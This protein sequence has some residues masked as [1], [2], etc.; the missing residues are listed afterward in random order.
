[1]S[2]T[3]T[4]KIND[5]R[6]IQLTDQPNMVC[7]IDYEYV[8]VNDNDR[9]QMY[10]G[11]ARLNTVDVESFVSFEELTEEVIVGWLEDIW[12]DTHYTH[13][14]EQINARLDAPVI[15]SAAKPWEPEPEPEV[16]SVAP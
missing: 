3:F 1:M 8:G 12:S 16:G 7:Q 13:M 5:L 10:I 9:A 2:T 11:T 14:Q 6:V 15:T 4:L